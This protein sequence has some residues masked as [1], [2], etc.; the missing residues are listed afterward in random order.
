M[1]QTCTRRGQYLT[2]SGPDWFCQPARPSGWPIL[3]LRI[4]VACSMR[5]TVR[6]GGAA[7]YC[8]AISCD[9]LGR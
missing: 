6:P 7:V 1:R 9:G 2:E 3:V 4:V 8:V 5:V